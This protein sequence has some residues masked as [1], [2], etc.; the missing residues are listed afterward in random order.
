[1]LFKY[2][3]ELQR[4]ADIVTDVPLI[5]VTSTKPDRFE[6]LEEMHALARL[7]RGS[8]S[9]NSLSSLPPPY[10]FHGK[11]IQ[12]VFQDFVTRLRAPEDSTAIEPFTYS[13]FAVIDSDCL[14]KRPWECIVCT[15]AVAFVDG[16]PHEDLKLLRMPLGEGLCTALGTIE[17]M[18][19][20]PN[21]VCDSEGQT[22]WP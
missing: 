21:E 22:Y 9:S 7:H 6:A 10:P 16:E 14:N 13:T 20:A 4:H 18:I 12:Q 19:V 5:E 11:T 2:F 17:A 3:E 1:M 8:S 15:D